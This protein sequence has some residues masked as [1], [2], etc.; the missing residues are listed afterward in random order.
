[1]RLSNSEV[2]LY[3]DTLIV[4]TLLTDSHLLKTAQTGGIVSDIIS[5]VKD[6]FGNHVD[7][8]DKAGSLLTMLAPGALTLTLKALGF[9]WMG[10]LLGLCLTIFHIDVA[11]ILRTVWSKLKE[12]L[13]GSKQV[14]SSQVD[15]IVDS[16]VGDHA[17]P[18][19]EQEAAA[20]AKSTDQPPAEKKEGSNLLRDAKLLKLALVEFENNNYTLSKEAG[21]LDMFSSRKSSTA[22]FLGLV[23]KWIFKV[24]I[25]SAGLMVAG[26]VVN[27]FIGRPNALDGT[28]QASNPTA[29]TSAPAA[30]VQKYTPKQKKF[31]LNPGYHEENKNQGGNLWIENVQNSPAGISTML[32]GFAKQVYQG[33]DRL[34]SIITPTPGFQTLV[35][36]IGYKNQNAAGGPVVFI[37]PAFTSKK[38]LVDLFIDEVAEKAP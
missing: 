3:V 31:P 37:P 12:V 6:Y 29:T 15:S 21:L 28:Y 22:S 2:S 17:P 25:A 16:A 30:A 14:S 34:D 1:M 26:D 8:N 9:G 36:T 20:A 24:A 5:K 4:Q 10:P 23:L 13:G 38:M 7:S 19:T 35:E 11:G 33:L 18:A 27:K 32:L